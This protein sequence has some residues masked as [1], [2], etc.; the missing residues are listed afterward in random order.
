MLVIK[1]EER[2]HFEHLLKFLLAVHNFKIWCGCVKV[3]G[4]GGRKKNQLMRQII[5]V[6]CA[7]I[8]LG[9]LIKVVGQPKLHFNKQASLPVLLSP[10]PCLDI[11]DVS[12]TP[13]DSAI[14][15]ESYRLECTVGSTDQ[16]D[17]TWVDNG[18]EIT[19]TTARVVSNITG[20]AGSYSSS[21]T[22]VFS[23]E[24]F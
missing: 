20:S 10:S 17:I 9:P 18:T 14:A 3:G 23:T 7:S 2:G 12:I 4:E 13:S 19:S 11:T 1:F 21:Y 24:S 5:I 15:G 16:P 8:R 22:D 6:C